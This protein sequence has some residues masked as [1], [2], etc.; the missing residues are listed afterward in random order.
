M[1]S[2][3]AQGP[4]VGSV[5][6]GPGV[7][8]GSVLLGFLADDVEVVIEMHLDLASAATLATSFC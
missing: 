4:L 2:S 1:S 6:V 5:V 8:G 7:V 3:L